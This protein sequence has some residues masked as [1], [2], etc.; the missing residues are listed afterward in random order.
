MVGGGWGQPQLNPAATL[1]VTIAYRFILM[2]LTCVVCDWQVRK[3]QCSP[4]H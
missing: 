4:W 3:Y 2:Y 1:L